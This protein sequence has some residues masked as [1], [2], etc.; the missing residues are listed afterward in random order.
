MQ[1]N[2]ALREV[3]SLKEQRVVQRVMHTMQQQQAQNQR[4][5]VFMGEAAE[6]NTTLPDEAK[7]LDAGGRVNMASPAFQAMAAQAWSQFNMPPQALAQS[8]EVL[9]YCANSMARRFNGAVANTA[10]F[11]K[12]QIINQKKQIAKRTGIES[13]DAPQ[14]PPVSGASAKFKEM[15]RRAKSGDRE[16]MVW[17]NAQS[18]G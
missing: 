7:F 11:N 17:L 18:L 14:K 8:P 6:V 2:S 13:G 5:G 4:F 9:A 15:E 3:E 1:Y 10:A 12:Q 16:A